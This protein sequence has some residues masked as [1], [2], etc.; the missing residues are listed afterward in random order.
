MPGQGKSYTSAS[1]G[2]LVVDGFQRLLLTSTML[3]KLKFS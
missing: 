1:H 2:N 3:S